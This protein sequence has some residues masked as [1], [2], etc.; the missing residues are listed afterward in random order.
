MVIYASES[1]RLLFEEKSQVSLAESLASEA[2]A[3]KKVLYVEPGCPK[4]NRVIFFLLHCGA[5]DAI[6]IE[7]KSPATD[8]LIESWFETDAEADAREA[9][10]KYAEEE[11][12]ERRSGHALRKSAKARAD[13]A[14]VAK[15]AEEAEASRAP[16]EYPVLVYAEVAGAGDD[17]A[18]EEVPLRDADEIVAH[19]AEAH[20]ADVKAFDAGGWSYGGDDDE[21]PD[22]NWHRGEGGIY[23]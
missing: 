3:F 11:K 2:S 19:F 22:W 17:L 23:G 13:A 18:L 21:D 4:C 9:A 1:D 12:A 5:Y 8:A 14:A 7:T 16:A 6:K 10:A 15:A 20:G